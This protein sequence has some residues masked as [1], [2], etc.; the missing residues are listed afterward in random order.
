[1]NELGKFP[2]AALRPAVQL[3]LPFTRFET[4]INRLLW[5]ASTEEEVEALVDLIQLH[6]EDSWGAGELGG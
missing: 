2:T 4:G 5:K 6:W 1:M 3:I